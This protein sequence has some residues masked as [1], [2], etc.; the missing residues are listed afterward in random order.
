MRSANK[1][2]RWVRHMTG[3]VRCSDSFVREMDAQLAPEFRKQTGLELSEF[4]LAPEGPEMYVVRRNGP[5]GYVVATIVGSRLGFQVVIAWV[6]PPQTRF[7]EPTDEVTTK[8]VRFWWQQLPAEEL[9]AEEKNWPEPPFDP[10][11]FSFKIDFKL[12]IWPHVSFT[13]AF[14]EPL[15]D[16]RR[17]RLDASFAALQ[18]DWRGLGKSGN[19]H[20]VEIRPIDDRTI[21]ARIDLGSAVHEGMVFV[22]ER[23]AAFG[24]VASLKIR[25]Y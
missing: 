12:K 16:E 17:A 15:D 19:F 1:A 6:N 22:L 10:D 21:E 18:P 5:V 13:I 9:V 7:I 2:P 11:L 24:G 20:D 23:L 25:A 3:Y 8:D 14:S 4:L